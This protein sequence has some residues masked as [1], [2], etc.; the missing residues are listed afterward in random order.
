MRT[1]IFLGAMMIADSINQEWIDK[2]HAPFF[3]IVF[4]IIAIMDIVDFFRG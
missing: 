4:I 1:V 3:A 2:N